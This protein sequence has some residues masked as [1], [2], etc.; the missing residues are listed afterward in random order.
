MRILNQDLL[1]FTGTT[2]YYYSNLFPRIAYTDGIRHLRTDLGLNWLIDKISAEL[3]VLDIEPNSICLRRLDS[4]KDT[5]EVLYK[6]GDLVRSTGR[7]WSDFDYDYLDLVVGPSV[8]PQ[9]DFII[10]LPS[11]N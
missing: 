7:F 4:D 3:P 11:E 1:G 9:H 6:Q 5:F 8:I 10:C 2:D